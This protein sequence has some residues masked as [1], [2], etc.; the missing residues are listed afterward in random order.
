ML[1]RVMQT[2]ESFDLDW[3]RANRMKMPPRAA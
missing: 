1:L 2:V 3:W